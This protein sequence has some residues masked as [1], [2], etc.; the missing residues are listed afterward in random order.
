MPKDHLNAKI[1]DSRIR[2]AKVGGKERL[3]GYCLGPVSVMLMN[4][5]LN[6]YLNVYYTDVIRLGEVWN[7]WFLTAFPIV[8]KL[9]DAFTYILMGALMSRFHSRQG[10][11]RPWILFSAP[12]LCV[13]MILLFAVPD[14]SEN[15]LALW[16]FFSYNL[17]Y[18]VAYTAYNTAHT[19]MVPLSTPDREDRGRLSAFTNVQGMLS[20]MV[21]AVLFPTLIVPALGVNKS[22][23]VTLMVGIA[24]LA[25][26]LISF[27]YFFTRE[28]VTEEDRSRQSEK[29]QA[30][31]KKLPMRKQL[32]LCLRS[33]SWTV[34]MG[35]LILSH[36]V[37]LLSGFTTFYYCN[38]VLGSYNDGITQMLYYAVGNFLLGPGF[39]L[40]RPI[41]RKLGRRNAMAGGFLLAAAG[42]LLCFLHPTSLVWV[43]AGQVIKSLGLI[44][45]TYMIT[46]MLADALDDVGEVTGIRC[47][48]FSSAAYNV[49]ATVTTG[50]AMAA[51]NFGITRLGYIAPA[52][53]EPVPIQPEAIR[54]FFAFCAVGLPT[55]VYPVIA[56][57]LM[58]SPDD[59]KKK[60]T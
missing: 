19:L 27:E 25:L 29:P 44:P 57:V 5:I 34:L 55:F 31:E 50:L 54:R 43:L 42:T 1:F 3:L 52:L 38:W 32:R 41:C 2:T 7:G 58:F 59:R 40:A 11:A 49:I 33:R 48:G 23:W 46:A 24:V 4:S 51:L 53:G 22:S 21:V 10:V 8:V 30:E 36:L 9:I 28:R 13:S 15:M 20:G 17:F 6:N 26:P 56:G 16:I 35:Y 18:S 12:L 37:Q 47:D 39:F 60:L 45:S 14:G